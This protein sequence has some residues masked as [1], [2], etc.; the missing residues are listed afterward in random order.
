MY[1]FGPFYLDSVSRRLL[2]EGRTVQ[3]TSKMFDVLVLLVSRRSQLVKRDELL[4]AAW[5]GS[6]IE[7]SNL[8]VT[9][10]N[11]RK[12]LGESYQS[13]NYIETVSGRGYRFTARVRELS[14]VEA[15]ALDVP[16]RRPD[17]LARRANLIAVLPLI[18]DSGDPQVDYLC[19][20]ITEGIIHSLGQLPG[21]KVIAR[22][23]AFY[24]KG[25]DDIQRIAADLGVNA[26]ITGRV[27]QI[28][29]DLRVSAELV[30]VAD[31][32]RLWGAQYERKMSD[33]MYVQEDITRNISRKLCPR[34]T[35]GPTT[36]LG[37]PSTHNT[38]AYQLYLKGRYLWNQFHQS[39]VERAVKYF[40]QAI[41]EDVT[42]A[43]AY[44]G[45]ADAYLRLASMYLPPKELLPKAKAAALRAVE[46]DETIAEAR[47]SLAL[48]KLWH[49]HDW[50]GAEEEYLRAMSLNPNAVIPHQGYGS[51]LL[52]LG[53]FS[54][55]AAEYRLAQELDPLSLQLYVDL[56][57]ALY[58]VRSYDLASE[59]FLKAIEL[60]PNYYPARY[61][62]A[63]AQVQKE[64][65]QSA[66]DGLRLLCSSG[67]AYMALG[68][69]GYVYALS[70][71]PG[72]ARKIQEDLIVSVRHSYVPPYALLL[73]SLGVGN[74]E[75]ALAWAE[76]LY[77]ERSYWLLWLNILPELADLRR[78]P[79]FKTLLRQAGFPNIN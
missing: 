64:D 38:K 15:Q 70:G 23:T 3:L 55:A 65:Y 28:R 21:L 53:R 79:R 59:Q 47:A 45:L 61:A 76:E 66:I 40:E 50:P 33:I 1:E 60:E 25:R 67:E 41:A 68:M 17:D 10:S 6:D 77:A 42:F 14:L 7:E 48:V 71:Q 29:D 63:W 43:L 49:D 26:V 52:F 54:E 74:Q 72:E 37:K 19:E 36:S 24:Y 4:N 27:L 44:S 18:N 5:P 69:L 46:A 62:L 9:I 34:T 58:M 78:T 73:S 13:R 51:Y 11:L 32:T 56:G 31:G 30:W 39:S 75:Q 8:T 2:R 22:S 12:V 35:R 20:G 57:V 16:P